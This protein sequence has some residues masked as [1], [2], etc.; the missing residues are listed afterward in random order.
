M[1]GKGNKSYDF[2]TVSREHAD[3]FDFH[4]DFT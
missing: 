4:P 1:A 2:G 3:N